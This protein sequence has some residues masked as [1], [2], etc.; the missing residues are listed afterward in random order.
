MWIAWM[1]WRTCSA[2]CVRA[3]AAGQKLLAC[4]VGLLRVKN[5]DFPNTVVVFPLEKSTITSA[6]QSQALWACSRQAHATAPKAGH[7][8]SIAQQLLP[9]H[10]L[11]WPLRLHQLP[12]AVLSLTQKSGRLSTA[13]SA[14]AGGGV[15]VPR[16]ARYRTNMDKW[17]CEPLLYSVS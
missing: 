13:V 9:G 7:D 10:C 3:G 5:M 12:T 2:F 1:R 17:F 15:S 4:H 6:N 14:V 8:H 16:L 11:P